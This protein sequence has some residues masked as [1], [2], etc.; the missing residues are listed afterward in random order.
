MVEPCRLIGVRS[1]RWHAQWLMLHT[2]S[3]VL[4]HSFLLPLSRDCSLSPWISFLSFFF[5]LFHVFSALAHHVSPSLTT[6]SSLRNPLTS[7]INAPA[8]TPFSFPR[9]IH[10]SPFTCFSW[11]LFHFPLL[12]FT[13]TRCHTSL[14]FF[15]L[16][17]LRMSLCLHV[18]S[19]VD[20]PLNIIITDSC[21]NKYNRLFSFLLQL[22]HMVW[23]LRDVWF[24]LKR[25]GEKMGALDSS[26]AQSPPYLWVGRA[27]SLPVVLHLFMKYS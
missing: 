21:M 6:L 20:W 2:L 3:S 15:F 25:T 16:L 5:L 7:S 13:L 18:I 23:S 4:V 14:R 12:S 24:H 17:S 11:L 19:Q 27:K 8:L 9:L 26:P 1:F 10:H 22:K